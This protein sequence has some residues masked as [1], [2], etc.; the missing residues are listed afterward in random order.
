MNA[1]S[2]HSPPYSV[3]VPIVDIGHTAWLTAL[4]IPPLNYRIYKQFGLLSAW[5]ITVPI[6]PGPTS[7]AKLSGWVA[8]WWP[9]S[10]GTHNQS[11]HSFW[12]VIAQSTA[13]PTP[14]DA[15]R[16]GSVRW[17]PTPLACVG[18]LVTRLESLPFITPHVHPPRSLGACDASRSVARWWLWRSTRS[19]H[20]REPQRRPKG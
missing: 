2:V 15:P 19:E 7:T 12:V 13:K 9:T 11:T 20:L 16:L 6:F 8:W 18:R 1:K 10:C 14:G 17:R 5:A 3:G 4:H